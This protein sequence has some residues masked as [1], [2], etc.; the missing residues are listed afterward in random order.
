M[1]RLSLNNMCHDGQA[2]KAET[3]VDAA[4]ALA[5]FAALSDD[6]LLGASKNAVADDY[7]S[8]TRTVRGPRH[9]EVI[10]DRE[11]GSISREI[12]IWEPREISSEAI[13]TCS[14]VCEK[15]EAAMILATYG[16]GME[17]SEIEA[18]KEATQICPLKLKVEL[19]HFKYAVYWIGSSPKDTNRHTNIS[20]RNKRT[21]TKKTQAHKLQRLPSLPEMRNSKS[22]EDRLNKATR[23]PKEH[24][25]QKSPKTKTK[26][27]D[28]KAV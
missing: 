4:Y 6:D 26:P 3:R 20:D 28:R 19:Q 7:W 13:A 24:C 22:H 1:L 2:S 16:Y 23:Q 14:F 12:A 18:K 25:S 5:F 27:S 10:C 11:S 8:K 9:Y 15:F 17:I 21:K